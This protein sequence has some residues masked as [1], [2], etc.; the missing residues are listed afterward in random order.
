MTLYWVCI[1]SICNINQFIVNSRFDSNVVSTAFVQDYSILIR[2]VSRATFWNSTMLHSTKFYLYANLHTKW[3][4]NFVCSI[5]QLHP[6][7]Y[8]CNSSCPH[9]T[10][11]STPRQDW[12]KWLTYPPFRNKRDFPLV[13]EFWVLINT[14]CQTPPSSH[15]TH[16]S[17]G[18][19]LDQRRQTYCTHMRRGKD[20][21][22]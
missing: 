22:R 3:C 5:Q 2:Y 1:A 11:V 20:W 10:T 12:H 13:Q 8:Y 7:T 19:V 15:S 14:M 6:T 9:L 18:Q 4:L 17:R 21:S 16:C